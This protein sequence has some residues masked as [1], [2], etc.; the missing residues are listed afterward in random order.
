MRKYHLCLVN[1][2]GKLL[3][4]FTAEL[5]ENLIDTVLPDFVQNLFDENL[6]LCQGILLQKSLTKDI[7]V[8]ELNSE[9]VIR[10]RICQ[11]AVLKGNTVCPECSALESCKNKRSGTKRSLPRKTK[12][13]KKLKIDEN[14]VD[15]KPMTTV[16]NFFASQWKPN[17]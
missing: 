13:I 12:S 14:S 8:E 6:V 16:F 7:L 9:I 1:F 10:S 3:D 4:T 17:Y 11:Y 15:G 5:S 2:A